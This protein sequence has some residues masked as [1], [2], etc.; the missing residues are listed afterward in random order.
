[1][2]YNLNGFGTAFYGKRDFRVDGTFI[3]TEWLMLMYIPIIPIRSFRVRYQGPGEHRWYLGLGSSDKYAVYEKRFPH[4]KQVLYIYGYMTLLAAW[5][6]LA[7]STVV[8]LFPHA[9]DTTFRTTL[10]FAACI[11]P[12]PTPWILRYYAKQK[13]R[14]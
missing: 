8:S 13:L 9:H 6:Y 3:T 14:A 10:F 1:M 12:I 7:D 2:A 11:I 5:A 4:L